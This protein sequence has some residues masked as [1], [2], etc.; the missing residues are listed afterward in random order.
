[1][2][3]LRFPA[4][5]DGLGRLKF[6][7]PELRQNE[8]SRLVGKRVV[9]IVKREVLT[10]TIKQN[11]LQWAVYG[12]AVAE[13]VELVELATGLPVFQT[14]DDVHGFAK[15]NLLRKPVQTNRGE[16]NLLGTTTT[17]STTE[18]S[19]YIEMLCAKLASYGVYIPPMD[20]RIGR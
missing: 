18:H 8:L 10:R 19:L 6:D 4:V 11:N 16:I 2:S 15:L 9:E 12:E 3:E 20:E 14:S 13:G 17:L 1:M 7:A 5:I